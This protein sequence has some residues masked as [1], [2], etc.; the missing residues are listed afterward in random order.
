VVYAETPFRNMRM[1]LNQDGIKGARIK[2]TFQATEL[3]LPL[4]TA[5]LDLAP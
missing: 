1:P 2:V 3:S 4:E 5:F